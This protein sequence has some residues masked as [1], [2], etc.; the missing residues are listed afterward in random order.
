[1]TDEDNVI[2]GPWEGNPDAPEMTQ[3]QYDTAMQE[4]LATSDEE[5]LGMIISGSLELLTMN[6]LDKGS[7]YL[8]TDDKQAVTV[9]AVNEA[10]TALMDTLPEV[11]VSWDTLVADFTTN[12]DPGDEQ[13]EPATESE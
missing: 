13:D 1:M 8:Q 5:R 11:I 6:A 10:A 9:I 7:F 4:L 2:E 12:S 3:E